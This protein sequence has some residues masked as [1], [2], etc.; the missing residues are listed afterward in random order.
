[1]LGATP[2]SAAIAQSEISDSTGFHEMFARQHHSH[3]PR[4][5][6]AVA[7]GAFLLLEPS[8]GQANETVGVASK[9]S[10]CCPSVVRK[11]PS[12]RFSSH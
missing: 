11:M 12:E 1:V 8:R 2:I 9:L 4:A 7:A 3:Y 10:N 5:D 6:S